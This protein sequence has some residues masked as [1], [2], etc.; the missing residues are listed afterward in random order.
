MSIRR[1][2]RIRTG[3]HLREVPCP[4]IIEERGPHQLARHVRHVR[5]LT[6]LVILHRSRHLVLTAQLLAEETDR[7][8]PTQQF[9]SFLRTV[10]R[11]A[12][13]QIALHPQHVIERLTIV[14]EQPVLR[15]PN[16]RCNSLPERTEDTLRRSL[17]SGRHPVLVHTPDRR[18]VIDQGG[19]RV[20]RDTDHDRHPLAPIDAPLN[21]NRHHRGSLTLHR[22]I[23]RDVEVHL[24]GGFTVIEVNPQFSRNQEF[25]IERGLRPV[26]PLTLRRTGTHHNPVPATIRQGSRELG[27]GG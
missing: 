15:V 22:F 13:G 10:I 23:R 4:S 7:L 3:L 1:D 21:V 14:E 24:P 5:E 8:L 17:R 9:L 20:E 11:S 12:H 26:R 2:L 16:I 6:L 27:L 18:N 19:L 25:H